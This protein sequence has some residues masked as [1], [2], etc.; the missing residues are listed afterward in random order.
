M[1]FEFNSNRIGINGEL[2]VI[3]LYNSSEEMRLLRMH[4]EVLLADT[5]HGT[6]KEKKELFTIAAKDGNNKAFN[7]CRAY[8][9]NAQQWVFEL[10]FKECL[11]HFFGQTILSRVRLLITEGLLLSMFLYFKHWIGQSFSIRGP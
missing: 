1:Q 8:I 10:L 7:A 9:P 4:P 11:P 2:L 3:F 5:T 6:N